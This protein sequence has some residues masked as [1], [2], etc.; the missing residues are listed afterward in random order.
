[1]TFGIIIRDGGNVPRTIT[2]IQI[3]DGG[4][5]ARDISE[6][7]IRDSN[8]VSKLVFS[9]SSPMT[10][11]ASPETVSGISSGSGTITTN[12][13]TVTPTGGTPPYTYAWSL[14][15]HDG[16]GGTPAAD[17]PTS[18]TTT[19]TQTGIPPGESTSASWTCT[20]TDS[21]SNTAPATVNSFWSNL[22]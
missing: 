18:A 14:E 16:V 19:F 8:N 7:R 15:S 12:A 2:G 3:R 9:T 22:L 20:V 17:S 10:A 11:S 6:L 21:L 13:T 1:M 5:V 4:N